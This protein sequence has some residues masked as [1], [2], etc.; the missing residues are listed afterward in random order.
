MPGSLR[1]PEGLAQL[2]RPRREQLD[3]LLDVAPGRRGP[4]PGTRRELGERLAFA[5]L[6]QHEQRLLARVQ[7]PP[8]RPDRPAVPSDDPGDKVRALRDNGSGTV[9]ME[10]PLG[11]EAGV[12]ALAGLDGG[13]VA[14]VR[15]FLAMLRL[16]SSSRVL[17]EP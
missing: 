13:L 15:D 2:R 8:G 6:S 14:L 9:S 10:K 7:L 4:D 3:G 17:P 11:D 1:V 16:L 12:P 5:Q